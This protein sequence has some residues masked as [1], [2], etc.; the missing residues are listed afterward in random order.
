MTYCCFNIYFIHIFEISYKHSIQH[1]LKPIFK[2]M[3]DI[4]I[5][6]IL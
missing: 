4:H 1:L 5:P 6:Q 3:V 2:G